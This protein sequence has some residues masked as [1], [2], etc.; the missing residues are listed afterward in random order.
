MP[1]RESA[2][3][4]TVGDHRVSQSFVT[5]AVYGL[6]TVL[7]VLQA[8]ERHP[9]APWVGVITLLGT[10]VAVA[11][12]E[13][14]AHSIGAMLAG[15]HAMSLQELREIWHD[16]APVITGAQAPTVVLLLS[17]FGLIPVDLA[18]GVAQVV[19]FLLLFGYGW[20]ISALLSDRW[21]RH[22]LGGLV[23][24]AI[25]GIIVGIKAAFH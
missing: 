25:G 10:T 19:A 17:A 6:V 18:I 3:P 7:A 4:V 16:V 20:R 5:R 8:M 21:P 12:V 13:A 23:L 14:Y 24:V 9:P 1:H 11:L 15:R 2:S 22:L